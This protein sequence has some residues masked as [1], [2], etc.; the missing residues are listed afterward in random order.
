MAII[1]TTVTEA[2]EPIQKEKR[3]VPTFL[4][5]SAKLA[6]AEG[7]HRAFGLTVERIQ[8]GMIIT[9]DTFNVL[10]HQF[11]IAHAEQLGLVDLTAENIKRFINQYY[12]SYY[13][14]YK[15]EQQWSRAVLIESLDRLNDTRLLQPDQLGFIS[16]ILSDRDKLLDQRNAVICLPSIYDDPKWYQGLGVTIEEWQDSCAPYFK[17]YA[18]GVVLASALYPTNIQT[19]VSVHSINDIPTGHDSLTYDLFR[20]L[21]AGLSFMDA[22]KI[23]GMHEGHHSYLEYM[24]TAISGDGDY[25]FNH[26]TFIHEAFACMREGVGKEYQKIPVEY[27]ELMELLKS[28]Q[29]DSKKINNKI[30]YSAAPKFLAALHQLVQEQDTRFTDLQERYTYIEEKGILAA[31]KVRERKISRGEIIHH[32]L[33]EWIQELGIPEEA[34]RERFITM[35]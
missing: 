14:N 30:Y 7:R 27:D 2:R 29:E 26:S 33:K 17:K 22:A 4:A 9:N 20:A 28:P 6:V 10:A 34:V 8:G 18:T 15:E 23:S 1:E 3:N 19:G 32:L 24:L 31:L 25:T 5:E 13:Q 16:G 12:R 35:C 11:C 21:A